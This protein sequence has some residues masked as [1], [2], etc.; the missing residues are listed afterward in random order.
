MLYRQKADTYIRQFNETAVVTSTKTFNQKIVNESGTVFLCSLSY[1]PQ[2]LD[3]LAEKI[4]KSFV[5]VD[6]KTIKKD[7]EEFY[8]TLVDEGFIVKGETKKDLDAQ[9]LGLSANIKSMRVYVTERCNAA[10]PSCVNAMSRTKAEMPLENFSLLCKY[11][12]DNGIIH[13]KM[14]G[15][16]PTVHKDFEKLVEIAQ[17]NFSE[18]TIFTN[19]INGKIKNIKLRESDCVTYNF[20][21]NESI[22]KDNLYLEN[23]GNR[24]FQV[25]VLKDSDEI[26]LANRIVELVNIDKEKIGVALS[27]DC[28]ANIFKD[29][30]I[31]I[32]KLSNMEKVL[33]ENKIDF[34]YDHKIPMC[35][36]HGSNIHVENDGMCFVDIAGVID[37]DL[38]LRYCLL[39]SEKTLKIYDS[40]KFVDWNTFLNHLYKYSYSLRQKALDKICL[41]CHLFN[42]NCNGGCWVARD[43]VTKNDILENVAK[44]FWRY[45]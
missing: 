31:L 25:Q 13:L 14:M 33:S 5:G 15:G 43:F 11:L 9:E 40:Q 12:S 27:L 18:V 35:F 23:G 4:V 28:S 2:T 44:D 24:N 38:T 36:L 19:G 6:V 7:A 39:F 37:S 42:R 20:L 16:E 32:E 3:E 21:F 26:K 10:C 41:D 17:S 30:K 1:Q 22:T 29:R 34:G 8:D 45:R